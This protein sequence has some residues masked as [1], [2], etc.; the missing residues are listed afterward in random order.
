MV[1]V[2]ALVML[3]LSGVQLQAKEPITGTGFHMPASNSHERSGIRLHAS[4]R[5][6]EAGT[7]SLAADRI[8]RADSI[9]ALRNRN[10][11]T[12]RLL[13]DTRYVNQAMGIYKDVLTTTTDPLERGEA[14]WKLQ[15]A[16]FFK[17][18]FGS[19]STEARQEIYWQGIEIGE[20]YIKKIPESVEA[21]MWLGINWA[22]WAEIAGNMTAA[23]AGAPD[24]IKSYAEKTIAL[25]PYYLDAGGYRLLGTLNIS[26]PRIPI[27]MGWPS[28]KEGLRLLEK[29]YSIA[30]DNLYNKMYLAIALH[31]EGKKKRAESL[32]NEIIN[33]SEIVHDLAIDAFIKKE[34]REFLSNGF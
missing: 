16:C 7:Q 30:P 24:R 32:L 22:R 1:S 27:I 14:F 23:K 13:A 28:K 2:I 11:D 17:G 33:T 5:I 25:D 8:A 31:S 34:A 6:N 29:A 4:D 20:E 9:F 3:L 26:V 12:E 19:E 21:V 10:F 18:Q 15:Q